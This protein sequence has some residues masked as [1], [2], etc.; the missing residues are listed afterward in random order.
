MCFS[1]LNSGDSGD[2]VSFLSL[3]EKFIKFLLVLV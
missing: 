2:L 1:E 3:I